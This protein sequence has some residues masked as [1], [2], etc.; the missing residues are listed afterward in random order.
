MPRVVD[1]GRRDY[2]SALEAMRTLVRE[3]RA[4]QI[5]DTLVLVEHPAVVTVGVE[6]DDGAA[7]ASGL[8]VV[9]VERGGRATY[10]GPGQQVGYPIVD[11]DRR[12]RD[13]RRFVRDVEG[14]VIRALAP[15]GIRAE[16][17]SG[18]PGVWADGER[19]IASIGIAV[20]HW[21]TFHGFALNVDPDLA[22]FARFHPC[23]FDG[24]VMTSVAKE[25]D[26]PVSLEELRSPLVEA[27]EAQFSDGPIPMPAATVASAVAEPPG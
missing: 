4:G 18:R 14:I 12:G 2:V 21:V 7:A 20:D 15:L 9:S 17:I 16:H 25:L 22:A 3:R 8:P 23:G 1:W 19:K 10:H 13:V 26:R 6:G 24:S 27:W 5:E 11:L